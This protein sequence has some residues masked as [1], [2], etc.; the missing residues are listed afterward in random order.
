M[1]EVYRKDLATSYTVEN[2]MVNGEFRDLKWY[3]DRGYTTD[4]SV[5][6]GNQGSA[7]TG[8]YSPGSEAKGYGIGASLYKFFPEAVL[9]NF[10]KEWAK[11][12]DANI[13]LATTRQT[14]EW[15]KEFG[16]LEREDGSLI[17]SELE[18][19]GTKATYRE[20]LAEVGITDTSEFEGKFNELITGEV[21]AQEFQSRIDTVYTAVKDNIPQVEQLFRE[22]FQIDSDAPT[23]FAALINPDIEDK[24]LKGELKTLG[25]AGEAYA[26]G[27]TGSFNRFDQLRKAGLSQEG[28]RD[29]YQSA[30]I[31]DTMGTQ[32]GTDIGLA[33]LEEAAIGDVE[34]KKAVNLLGAEAAA[35]SSGKVGAA[36][37]GGKYTGLV[38]N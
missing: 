15:K 17:M 34:A 19:V 13:A 7:T 3:T 23:I 9:N 37:K 14:P 31:Y 24:L 33:T 20:T 27:F 16:Y 30:G 11:Y 18:A 38:Q 4:S 28:A 21:S 8:E 2:A 6:P 10:A 32:T 22:R 25:I 12:G 1:V 35:M 5:Q 26:A 29:L 36:R